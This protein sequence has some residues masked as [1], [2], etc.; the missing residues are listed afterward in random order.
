MKAPTI[1]DRAHEGAVAVEMA[2][3]LPLLMLLL[4]GIVDFGFMLNAQISL[5]HAAREGARVEAIGTGDAVTSA[6]VAFTAPAVV[7]GSFSAAVAR[8]CPHAD[9]AQLQTRATYEPFLLWILGPTELTSQAVM[10]CGG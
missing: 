5:T 10:R 2:I 1:G 9:G 8:A 3:L 6:T 4:G 7:S